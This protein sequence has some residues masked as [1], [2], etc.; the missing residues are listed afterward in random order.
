MNQVSGAVGVHAGEGLF[1]LGFQ[2]VDDPA[3]VVDAVAGLSETAED[4]LL[5]LRQVPAFDVRQN[6]LSGRLDRKSV[7]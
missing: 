6:L 7:V 1:A 3:D 4:Q 5:V 2:L